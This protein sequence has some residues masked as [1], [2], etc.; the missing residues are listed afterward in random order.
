MRYRKAKFFW[1]KNNSSKTISCIDYNDGME[2]YSFIKDCHNQGYRQ[3]IITSEL[4]IEIIT[5]FALEKNLLVFKIELAEDDSEL[6]EEI[7]S[8]IE[9]TEKNSIYFNRLIDELKFL[10]EK[11]SIDIQRVYMKGRNNEGSIINLFLQSNG[12]IGINTDSFDNVSNDIKSIIEEY[13]MQ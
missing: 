12:L 10:S 4:M 5:R 8:L 11:S 13:F 7:D 9:H 1:K 2:Y 6:A 3:I